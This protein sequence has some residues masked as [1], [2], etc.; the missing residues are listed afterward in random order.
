MYMVLGIDPGYTTGTCLLD[1]HGN[2]EIEVL[3]AHQYEWSVRFQIIPLVE[4]LVATGTR[5]TIVVE[6]F[7]LYPHKAQQLVGDDFPSVRVIGMVEAACWKANFAQLTFQT[8]S[9]IQRVQVLHDL[10]IKSEHVR[11]AYRHARYFIV[12]HKDELLAQATRTSTG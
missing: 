1:L 4:R 12:D 7:R 9:Q 3:E 11:D 2:G 6:S 5:V 8:A 10:P